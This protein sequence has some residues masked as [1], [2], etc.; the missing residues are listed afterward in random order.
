MKRF[1]TL[2]LSALLGFTVSA[3]AADPPDAFTVHRLDFKG[4]RSVSKKELSKTL[5]IKL[6]PRW[7]FWLPKPAVT[8]QELQDDTLRI[9]QFY[10]DQGFYHTEVKY[11]IG[12]VSGQDFEPS[13][14]KPLP[15]DLHITFT[16]AEG[17]PTLVESIKLEISPEM[18]KQIETELLQALPLKP[19]RVFKTADYREAKKIISKK[20]GN[21]GYPFA[22]LTGR[23]AVNTQR[24][25][26]QA[27]FTVTPGRQYT[28]GAVTIEKTDTPVKD[29]VVMRA[30]TFST[31]ALYSTDKV[32]SS[33]RNLYNLDVFRMALVK[34]EA[35]DPE[36][37]SVPMTIQLKPKK[38]QNVRLGVGYGTEDGF[39]VKGAWT[40]RNLWGWAGK[41]S[42]SAKRSDLIENVQADYMQPYFLDD[43]NTLRTK[44]GFEQEKFVSYT[45]RKI[46]ADA[47]IVRSFRP[48][49]SLS[50]GYNLELNKLVDIKLT[51]PE[52]LEAASSENNYLISSLIGGLNYNTA[53][54]T[55]DPKKG[56]AFSI[57]AEWASNLFGS[58]ISYFKPSLE[59]KRY[60]PLAGEL[61]LAGR[62]QIETLQTDDAA[63]IPIFKR[64]F[65]G[66]SNT[67]RGYGYQKLPPLDT[68]G[69]PL[70]GLS[71]FNAN[72]ELRHPLY[73]K[74][75]GVIFLDMGFLNE[76]YFQ[77]N[78]S[79]MRYSCGAGIRYNTILGP[80][81]LDLGYKLNPPEEDTDSSWRVHFS[82]GQAF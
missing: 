8:L 50:A 70:G 1:L 23:V 2:L 47:G 52:E 12:A 7:K 44:A 80:L 14:A 36:A 53:D 73:W 6:P 42:L 64:L 76:D 58:E 38:R 81:R 19:G 67:V 4:I 37:D 29:I 78:F 68:N 11:E 63:G 51:L 30:I 48:D 18:E 34:P 69:N 71:G 15:P 62:L 21:K 13:R 26:A 75:S 3:A 9:K 16:V 65:L 60:Q 49:W 24:N 61:I 72:A 74:I 10:R 32:E 57:S 20:L 33:Q 54:N 31:G 22:G 39:R 46:F 25:S 55:L 77:Y 40:Y 17:P 56:S 28:F 45:N 43:R 59:L 27:S 5:A 35:P 79:D 41:F 82:I 66:G